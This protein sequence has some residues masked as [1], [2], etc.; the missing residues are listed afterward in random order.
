MLF[1]IVFEIEKNFF[2]FLVS[3]NKFSSK[4]KVARH[5]HQSVGCRVNKNCKCS[6]L[7]SY[8]I[9]DEISMKNCYVYRLQRIKY[10]K[11]LNGNELSSNESEQNDDQK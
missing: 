6:M 4:N 8:I 2:F 5:K 9:A 10:H 7:S 1:V 11:L 3:S